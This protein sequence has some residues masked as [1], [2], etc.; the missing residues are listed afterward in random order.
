MENSKTWV[1]LVAVAIIAIVGFVFL[2]GGEKLAGVTNYDSIETEGLA[3]GDGC[4]NEGTTCVG[5]THT[6]FLSGTCN[7]TQSTVGSFAASSS[8]EH[9]CAVSNVA[10]G[11][12]VFV[13]LPRAAGTGSGSIGLVPLTSYATTSGAIGVVLANFVGVATTS[14]AQ[15]T[16]SVTYWIVDN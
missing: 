13:V 5:T 8:L 3:L 7:L 15:A 6:K 11:D 14:Y 16:T 9:F 2:S 10:S 1:A 12:K 4:D